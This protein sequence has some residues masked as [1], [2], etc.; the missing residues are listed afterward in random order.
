MANGRV[1][2]L[3][4]LPCSGKT[5]IAKELVKY[6]P[7]ASILDG[8]VVR[9]GPLGKNVGFSPEDREAHILRMGHVAKLMSETGTTVICSFV[10]PQRKVREEVRKMFG[11]GQFYEIHI[12]TSLAECERRDVKGMYAKARAGEIKDFTGI[13]APYEAPESP[14]L[15]MDT[16]G[17]S[18]QESVDRVLDMVSPY[19]ERA[20]FFIGRWNSVFHRGHE[21]I[22]RKKLDEGVPV[23]M[24]VRNVKPDEKNPWT[25]KEVKEM[26]DYQ[27][28]NE[29]RVKVIIIPDV[30]S[31]EYGRGV[32][33]EVNEIKVDKTI[34][35]I[36][37]TECRKL[38]AE[39]RDEWKEFVPPRI[40][41]FLE[42]RKK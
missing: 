28:E 35:G 30:A 6:Y 36:S 32:G 37:G 12:S 26:L 24:A 16:T 39:G 14:D 41:E 4:G 22:I 3:T 25:A 38:I 19:A 13:D 2:W 27:W 1:L 7:Q 18:V 5:T 17:M 20:A 10:S 29:P 8:D 21:T 15:A 34:A 31:V 42:N 23:I 33:Y 11:P 40:V 9:G